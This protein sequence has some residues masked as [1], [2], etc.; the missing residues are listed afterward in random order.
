METRSIVIICLLAAAVTALAIGLGVGLGTKDDTPD[1][2]AVYINEIKDQERFDC[3][4]KN[5]VEEDVDRNKCAERGCVWKSTSTDKMAPWCFYPLTWGYNVVRDDIVKTNVGWQAKLQR[6]NDQ[7]SRYNKDINTIQVDVE[8]QTDSRLR[9]KI[10]DPSRQRFEVPIDLPVPTTKAKNP[11]YDV[12]YQTRPFKFQVIRKSTGTKIFDTS[13]GGFTFEDQFLQISTLLPSKNLYGFGEHNHR[14]FRH[15]LDWKTWAIFTRDVAPIDEW[16]VYGAHPYHMVVEDDGNAHGI[17]LLNSNAMDVVLQPMPALTYR[18]IGG[19][20]DF[21]YFFGPSPENVVMQLSELIGMPLMPPYWALGFQLSRWHYGTL[22]RV[23]EVVNEVYEA[24]IPHD[25][26][27]GDI[28]IMLDKKDFTYDENTYKGL[29]EFIAEL[30]ARGQRYIP[31]LDHGI[32][33]EKGYATY[34]R[35]L[36]MS[37]YVNYSDGFRPLVGEVWPGKS[38]YPDFTNPKAI[39][40][41]TKELDLFRDIIDYDGIWIDMNEPSNFVKGSVE[42]CEVNSLNNPPYLPNI[43]GYWEGDLIDKT[44]CMDAKQFGGKHYDL[45]SLYGHTMSLVT[46]KALRELEPE[47]R[48][49]VVT[50]SHFTGT[51][52]YAQ[53]WLGDNQ[54]FWEQIGWSIVGMMEFSLFG[55]PYSGADICGFWSNATEELCTRW[56]QVGAFYPYSRN[57]N[58]KDMIPQHPTAFGPKMTKI[59]KE[60][61]TERYRL[62]PYLYSLLYEAHVFGSTVVRPMMHEFISDK[63][64]LD[65]DKQFMWGGGLLITPVLTKGSVEVEGYF[66]DARWY[67]YY[68]GNEL[69]VV[70]GMMRTLDAP[71]D[72]IPVHV[73]G[74]YILPIQEPANTTFYRVGDELEVVGGMMHTLDAPI[75]FIPVHVRGGYILPIQEP[76]NT[77]FY[78][79]VK[80]M[81]IIVAMDSDNAANGNLFWD[82]GESMDTYASGDYLQLSF[83]C[84]NNEIKITVENSGFDTDLILADIRV[85]GMPGN[86]S[87]VEVDDATIDSSRYKYSKGNKEQDNLKT[88]PFSKRTEIILLQMAEYRYIDRYPSKRRLNNRRYK[89]EYEEWD[90]LWKPRF[91]VPP[92]AFNMP[93]VLRMASERDYIINYTMDPFHFKV[94]RKKTGTTLFD[95]SYGGLISE[96]HY[97]EITTKLPSANVYG[98]SQMR[99]TRYRH[100]LELWKTW[101]MFPLDSPPQENWNSYGQH[102][103][104]MVVEDDGNAF[105]VFLLNSNAQDVSLQ[106]LPSLTWRSTGGVFDFWMFLGP[107]PEDVVKA[108]T[109]AIGRPE[110]PPYWALGYQ[111]SHD[112]WG[113]L[114]EIESV[115]KRNRDA[116]IPVEAFYSGLDYMYNYRSFTYD[117]RAEAY[118]DLPKFIK[119]LHMRGQKYIITLLPSIP[120]TLDRKEYPAYPEGIWQGVFVNNTLGASEYW[121]WEQDRE[122]KPT[123]GKVNECIHLNLSSNRLSHRMSMSGVKIMPITERLCRHC[124]LCYTDYN[125]PSNMVNG[126]TKGCENPYL[127]YPPYAPNLRYGSKLF[128]KTL[129]MDSKQTWGDHYDVHSLYGHSSAQATHY[130][131]SIIFANKRP[132]VVSRSTFSG[133]GMYSGGW[134]GHNKAEWS[135]LFYS[136]HEMLRLNINGIPFVG[137]D[138]CG[139]YNASDE[140]LCTR[141]HQLGS[142]YPLMRNHN[143][144][145]TADKDP[146]SYGEPLV[147]N[148]RS[149][150]ETRYTLLPY[151]YTL[152]YHA[153]YDGNTVARP[154][155]HEFPLEEDAWEVDWQF[156]WGPALLI[157]PVLEEGKTTVNAYI[158]DDRWYDYYTKDSL[159]K[160]YEGR[161]A[162]LDAPIDKINLHIRGGY[163]IPTQE[164]GNTTHHSRQ[165]NMG[166][167]VAL[168][169]YGNDLAV[170]DLFWD[171]GDSKEHYERRED[172]E[173]DYDDMYLYFEADEN[174]LRIRSDRRGLIARY[175]DMVLPVFTT[176]TFL[177]VSSE[178]SRVVVDNK[179]WPASDYKFER[180]QS[181]NVSRN[182]I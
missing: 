18:T 128:A 32:K 37:I 101:P 107:K 82:D 116:G 78:S 13:Y 16:N 127:N 9:V 33:I 109:E 27:Y 91:E 165:N 31:I 52:P 14:Q 41:W 59:V 126:T 171:D 48:P 173:S 43:L 95:T 44:I 108:F 66:P 169:E 140:E 172:D 17:L 122:F 70:G 29:P 106:P 97:L 28:D 85:Y 57:H 86:P 25:V 45:H 147:T 100:E 68:T 154:V 125:E 132:M 151:L 146:A 138:I 175:P 61:L 158:P 160:T 163:V 54:S 149:A 79:R 182:Y 75:D 71:I 131:G 120:N 62:L 55:F 88:L 114:A 134:L 89:E 56:H 176:V 144:P 99:Q 162:T 5:G 180:H 39:E 51:S 19:I 145:G 130:A 76:A 77:T 110:I 69:E 64:T 135:E 139:Y 73:R 177:G 35:G 96:D 168:P 49:L 50:R 10:F 111:L 94:I 60:I 47:K 26:Q 2:D 3:Y 155:F 98:F 142:F 102:P 113:G 81:G 36:S 170:G 118:G 167:I 90:R 8:M 133:T 153:Q 164:P 117:T 115:A 103:F 11:M 21:Y 92:E 7:P 148:I 67:D 152:F 174:Q 124:M 6:L 181:S 65:I 156:M 143:S 121:K 136:I 159:P 40:W 83:K 93:K 157:T 137:A 20:F 12:T 119:D 179:D 112:K 58:C 63:A 30:H 105:G 87:T 1:P 42:G 74:G 178:P 46:F 72:V 22:E 123:V 161:N 23:K 53:H 166:L 15:N 80:N 38:V 141:W 129:C 24:D 34:D 104:Y 150:M 84:N 4:P